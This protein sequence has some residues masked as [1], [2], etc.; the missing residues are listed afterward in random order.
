VLCHV[1]EHLPA[2]QDAVATLSACETLTR[3]LIAWPVLERWV[4]RGLAGALNFEHCTYVTRAT[5]IALFAAQGWHLHAQAD[6]PENDT[7]FL[8]F[9]RG[10]KV[11]RHTLSAS[12]RETID[13]IAGYY[14]HFQ[15]AALRIER[16]VAMHRGDAFLMPASVYTQTLLMSGL[17]ETRFRAVLDNAP[18]KQGGRL[19]GTALPVAAPAQALGD[20]DHP[21]VVLNGGAHCVEII[22]GL[23]DIRGD[24]EIVKVSEGTMH[25]DRATAQ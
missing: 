4:A 23:K 18:Q 25:G 5:L 8:S 6:W 21:L 1:L 20:A 7:A 3:V 13:A 9:A 2:L 10:E 14:A 16:A 24:A 12:P 19:Y 22:R 11:A 17:K 15:I